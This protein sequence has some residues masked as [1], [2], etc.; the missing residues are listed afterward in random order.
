MK[1]T[2]IDKRKE[3]GD[4]TSFIL[5]PEPPAADAAPFT[6]QAGQFLHYTLPHD[7]PDDRKMER[8]FTI[9][10]APHEGHIMITTR[11]LPDASKM[12][13]FKK[14][15]ASLPIGGTIEADGPDGDFVIEN[16][17]AEFV[18]IA[19]GIGI[20]PYRAILLDLDSRGVDIHARLL[21]S[22]RN[23]DFVFKSELDALA[24]KHKN[25]TIRYIVD[26]EKIDEAMIRQEIPD[27]TKPI[28]YVSGPEPM[29][30][31][32]EKWMLAMGIPEAHLKRDYFPGY[33]WP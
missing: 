22:N 29:T 30:E 2:L 3:A 23:Q 21:Y 10:A 12:S 14:T 17:A 15:L 25:F 5:K 6:W 27:L 24:Q 4:A 28:V 11:L 18:F 1:L 33:N 7:N 19:G 9:S 32:F 31:A 8:Y 13:S 26:P 20:T 16:P